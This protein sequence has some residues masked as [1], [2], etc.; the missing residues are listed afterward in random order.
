[1]R[2]RVKNQPISDQCNWIDQKEYG[3]LKIYIWIVFQLE[4]MRLNSLILDWSS[5]FDALS[6]YELHNMYFR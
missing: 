5:L 3:N 1:M 4:P 6:Y 2:D